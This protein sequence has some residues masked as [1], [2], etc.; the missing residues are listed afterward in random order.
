MS[1]DCTS[2]TIR[3]LFMAALCNKVGHYIFVLK[4]LLRSFFLWPPCVAD[5]DIIFLPCAFFPRLISA[6]AEYIST[7]LLHMVWP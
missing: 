4:F 7:V 1:V 2:Y 6:V 3:L 5:A